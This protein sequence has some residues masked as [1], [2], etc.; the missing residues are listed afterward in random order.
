MKCSV[1]PLPVC[2][3]TPND[4]LSSMKILT[5]YSY[6]SSICNRWIHHR[7]KKSSMY[8]L[9]VIIINLLGAEQ[10]CPVNHTCTHRSHYQHCLGNNVCFHVWAFEFNFMMF[11]DHT[12]KCHL[13]IFKEKQA[14]FFEPHTLV[15]L[16]L[17]QIKSSFKIIPSFRNKHA[18]L[19]N[20]AT[21]Y[22]NNNNF[23]YRPNRLTQCC[24]QF[25]PFGNKTFC[26]RNFHI[27]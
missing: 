16:C 8:S 9:K 22:S 25:K 11:L 23:Y 12:S 1:N 24:T 4:A 19:S 20:E 21:N 17:I 5:L 3:R 27:I 6:L 14:V 2:P 13:H 15:L 18:D 7:Q 26:F 10:A